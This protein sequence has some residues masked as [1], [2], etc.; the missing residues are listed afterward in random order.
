MPLVN[1]LN[2]ILSWASKDKPRVIFVVND[3][4]IIHSPYLENAPKRKPDIILVTLDTFKQWYSLGDVTFDRCRR[5]AAHPQELSAA[6]PRTWS[7]VIQ[8]WEL[9]AEDVEPSAVDILQQY[10]DNGITK[11]TIRQSTLG[12][13]YS[14]CVSWYSR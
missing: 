14:C 5:M 13:C 12:R 3:P 8:F 1:A 10:S 7:D 11:S 4:V 6:V 2:A 9:K